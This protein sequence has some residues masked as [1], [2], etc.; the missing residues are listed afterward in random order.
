MM[1][2]KPKFWDKKNN[3][4]SFILLPLSCLY[5][6]II[7][8]KRKFIKVYK[9]KIPI[10]CLGNIYIGGTGKTPLSILLASELSKSGK[11]VSILRRYHKSHEDE[12]NLIK[13]NFKNFIISKD[14]IFGIKEAERDNFDYIVL[15][16]GL[17]DYR[18]H[19]KVKIV[20]F[21][22]NQLIGNG[23]VLPS[24]PLRE[25]LSSLKNTHIVIIN[26]NKSEKFEK[27]IFN[28]NKNLKIFYSSYQPKNIDT[29]K[30]KE[31]VAIAGIGNPEN[32]FQLIEKNNLT[33]KKKIIFPDQYKFSR[34]EIQTIVDDALKENYQV[35]MTEK[36]YYKIIDYK[37]NGIDYLKV[38]LIINN[39]E[40]FI[41]L[42]KELSDENN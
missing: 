3:L 25:R 38:D 42:I 4:I 7:F 15:D 27:I 22:S 23:L 40:N 11:K 12:Y 33:I 8:L 1:F 39:K 18:I 36:D 13:N 6:L 20:C 17:Q 32:F 28:I 41:S 5:L 9:F 2:N 21:N 35:I 34:N 30:N 14:R 26:G 19:K 31:L 10:I 37:I 24:G 29:F 16:D